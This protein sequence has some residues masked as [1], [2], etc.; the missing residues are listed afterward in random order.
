MDEDRAQSLKYRLDNE[1]ALLSRASERFLFGWDVFGRNRIYDEQTVRD[2]NV[3][4][5]QWII[6]I[7]QFGLVGFL[8]QFG[9][10]AL[11]VIERQR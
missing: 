10:L 5:G 2:M 1:Q 9:L 4:D 7:G 6:T 3:T 8:L 11:P